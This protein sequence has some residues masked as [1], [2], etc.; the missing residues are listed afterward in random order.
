[1]SQRTLSSLRW[2][3][4][5][6]LP[7]GGVAAGVLILVSDH[8][9][10]PSPAVVIYPSPP[11]VTFIV[12]TPLPTVPPTPTVTEASVLDEPLPD[13]TLTTLDGGALHLADLEGQIVFLNF[14]ATWC[15]PCQEEM[16]ALQALQDA[17]GAEGV[18]VIA[19]TDPTAGQ[20]EADV[21][22]F[23]ETYHLTFTVVLSSDTAVYQ[24]FGVAQIPMTYII[25]REGIIRYRQI[26][27][28]DSEDIAI[29]LQ[30]LTG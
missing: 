24:H 17:H 12:P 20:S 10:S 18:R 1:M 27:T 2:L 5:L 7:L 6:I 19:V 29:Y 11:P 13:F 16:P 14:W 25:D 23:L 9:A 15:A 30:R 4:F 22:A 21:R 28:L 26:G 8:G 3:L